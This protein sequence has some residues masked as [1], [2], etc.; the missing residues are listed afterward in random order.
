MKPDH[1]SQSEWVGPQ[2][3]TVHG[4]QACEDFLYI[5]ILTSQPKRRGVLSAVAACSP[6]ANDLLNYESL[7]PLIHQYS[8]DEKKKFLLHF[9][10]I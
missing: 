5:K 6:K 10:L 1:S 8:L 9:L 7:H 3:T 4:I 2:T